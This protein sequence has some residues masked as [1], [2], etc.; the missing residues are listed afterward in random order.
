LPPPPP[1]FDGS[2]FRLVAGP[3]LAAVWS[4]ARGL[5]AMVVARAVAPTASSSGIPFETA[6]DYLLSLPGLP[7]D[8]ASQLSSFSGD[9]TTLPLPVPAE[10][11]TSSAADVDGV[12][13]TVLTSRDGA[14]AVVVWVDDGIVTAVAGSLSDDEVLSVARGLR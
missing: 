11:M 3:G 4:D 9:G 1:G 12:P 6:R 14:M 2:Q 8:V 5:P 13:A 10:L 7:E